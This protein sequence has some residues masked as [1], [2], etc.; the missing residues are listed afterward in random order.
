MGVH[1]FFALSGFLI[2]WWLVQEYE[3]LGRIDWKDFYIRRA[4]RI[5]PAA[6]VYLS[7]LAIAGF[8]FHLIPLDG[9]Q[10][11]GSFLFFRNYLTAAVPQSWY[12]G[13]F[14]SLA[15]EEHFYLVW[16]LLLVLAGFRKAR[17]LAP[18]L[19]I[20]V[21]LWR[22][23]DGRYE[24]VARIDP[25]LKDSVQRTDYRLDILF[26]GCAVALFWTQ[27]TVHRALKRVSGSAFVVSIF[28]ATAACLYWQPRG[29][30]TMLAILMAL[31]PAATVA[32]PDGFIS[33]VLEL[34]VLRWIGRLSYSLYLWQQL[35]F[36]T[37]GVPSTLGRLQTW[38]WNVLAAFAAAA[39]SYY[40]VERPGIAYGKAIREA[41][42]GRK[43]ADSR[44]FQ[45]DA[46]LQPGLAAEIA[47]SD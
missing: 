33:R 41:R 34:P 19:A 21:G 9:L 1:L 13:H 28:G 38:P 10:L 27:P 7:A 5:L 16:P 22:F 12:T 2:T 20:C 8:G 43:T 18:L 25:L 46:D 45:H 32:Y 14:W 39:L 31:L 4:F 42:L 40:V 36:P 17:F 26:C 47:K 30:L 3:K 11:A 23:L 24:W 35:F 44:S 6:F 37:F 15:V 29:Y